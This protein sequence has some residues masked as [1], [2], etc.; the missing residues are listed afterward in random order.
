[1]GY[2]LARNS[3]LFQQ[4]LTA[5]L[6]APGVPA[7]GRVPLNA[8]LRQAVNASLERL[9]VRASMGRMV[10]HNARSPCDYHHCHL[11]SCG[12]R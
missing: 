5:S 3:N 10:L 6:D 4:Y 12:C 8:R 1:M 11:L 2:F 7:Q 9:Q